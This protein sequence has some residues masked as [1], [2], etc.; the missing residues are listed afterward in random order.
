M[1]VE[2]YLR[3]NFMKIVIIL[4]TILLITGC[5]KRESVYLE[6]YTLLGEWERVAIMFG[7]YDNFEACLEINNALTEKYPGNVYRCITNNNPLASVVFETL[8]Y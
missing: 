3:D 7:Y 5:S 4:F 6:K 1:Q 2:D 8:K